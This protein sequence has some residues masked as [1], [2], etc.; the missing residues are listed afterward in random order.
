LGANKGLFTLW[1]APQLPSGR[2]IAV[3]PGSVFEVL[4]SN[5]ERN[6]LTNVT[7][8]NAAAGRPDGELEL[9]VYSSGWDGLSHST[10]AKVPRL[11]SLVLSRAERKVVTVPTLSVAQILDRADVA[12]VK[13]LKG[14]VEGGEYDIFDAMSADDWNRIAYVVL[15]FH[16]FGEGRNESQ[17]LATLEANGFDVDVRRSVLERAQGV[18]FLWASK[19][20]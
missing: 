9:L 18:G 12:A 15:E 5:V 2:V 1:A 4:A 19:Q 13:L 14:D 8:I 16:R 6:H 20:G 3:E 17:L 7:A 11:T 10:A